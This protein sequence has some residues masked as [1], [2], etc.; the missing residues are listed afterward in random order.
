MPSLPAWQSVMRC[1]FKGAAF[2]RRWIAASDKQRR[3]PSDL[4]ERFLANAARG[5]R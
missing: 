5:E 3:E 2:S 4:F 1:M